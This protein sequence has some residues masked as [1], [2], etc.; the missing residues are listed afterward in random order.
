VRAAA[1]KVRVAAARAW[2]AVA[3]VD[4]PAGMG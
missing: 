1:A 2:A 4:D 3:D